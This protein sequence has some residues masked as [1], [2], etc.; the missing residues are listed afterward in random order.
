MGVGEKGA[1]SSLIRYTV[2]FQP[3]AKKALVAASQEDRLRITAAI[4]LLRENPLP[5]KALKLKGR[6]GYRIRVGKYRIIYG[7]DG[8]E[9]VII[10][11]DIGPRRDIYLRTL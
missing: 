4:E 1:W 6:E 2:S 10:V 5:P 9:L 7:F 11:L 3:K 8:T